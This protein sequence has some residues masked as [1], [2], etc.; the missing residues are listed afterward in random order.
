MLS[1]AFCEQ[2]PHAKDVMTIAASS[3]VVPIIESPDC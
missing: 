2:A 1:A 3:L